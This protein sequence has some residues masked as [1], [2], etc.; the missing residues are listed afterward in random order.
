MASSEHQPSSDPSAIAAGL[1]GVELGTEAAKSKESVAAEN[2]TKFLR[3]PAQRVRVR[4]NN[5]QYDSDEK[6]G[7]SEQP[8]KRKCRPK[9]ADDKF[10]LKKRNVKDAIAKPVKAKSDRVKKDEDASKKRKYVRKKKVQS[11]VAVEQGEV[12]APCPPFAEEGKL[13]D[14]ECIGAVI[15]GDTLLA[16]VTGEDFRGTCRRAL[17]FR[18]EDLFSENSVLCSREN[19][20][21]AVALEPP[22]VQEVK[23]NYTQ[24]SRAMEPPFIEE[25]IMNNSEAADKQMDNEASESFWLEHGR[26][27][28]DI[29]T[30]RVY[31]RKKKVQGTVNSQ[32]SVVVSTEQPS[33]ELVKSD[34]TGTTG[35]ADTSVILLPAVD[36]DN[37]GSRRP[38]WDCQVENLKMSRSASSSKLKKKDSFEIVFN[39]LVANGK[40]LRACQCIQLI[41]KG[42]LNVH[43]DMK[44]QRAIRRMRVDM[45]RLH[46]SFQSLIAMSSKEPTLLQELSKPIQKKRSRTVTRRRKFGPLLAVPEFKMLPTRAIEQQRSIKLLKTENTEK[47]PTHDS[48][49]TSSKGTLLS[50]KEKVCFR[51][52]ELDLNEEPQPRFAELDP[53]AADG[54]HLYTTDVMG[55]DAYASQSYVANH[56]KS[57][58][59][60]EDGYFTNHQH[61]YNSPLSLATI[62]GPFVWTG[63]QIPVQNIGYTMG[64]CYSSQNCS[65]LQTNFA[66]GEGTEPLWD[67]TCNNI[68]FPSFANELVSIPVVRGG[69]TTTSDT[70]YH[71]NLYQ[72][73]VPH[74]GH[75]IEQGFVAE[76]DN[77]MFNNY[78]LVPSG[79]SSKLTLGQE[80]VTRV[81]NSLDVID[82]LGNY[83]LATSSIR[84]KVKAHVNFDSKTMPMWRALMGKE[85]FGDHQCNEDEE[86]KKWWKEERLIFEEKVLAFISCMHKIQGNRRFSPWNGSVTDSTMGVF[87]TQNVS[88]HLSSSA[89]MSLAAKFPVKSTNSDEAAQEEHE[90]VIITS[91]ESSGSNET[92]VVSPSELLDQGCLSERLSD[93][94]QAAQLQNSIRAVSGDQFA[95]QK[96][97]EDHLAISVSAFDG[98][99]DWLSQQGQTIQHQDSSDPKSETESCLSQPEQLTHPQD[100]SYSK[101]ETEPQDSSLPKSETEDCLSRLQQTTLPQA[102]SP[103][104]SETEECLSQVEQKT[105]F[106]DA[107]HPKCE[108]EERLSRQEELTTQP[109]DS[110]LATSETDEL[111]SQQEQ[112]TQ[113]QDSSQPIS[114]TE[115]T[116]PGPKVQKNKTPKIN[117]LE[118]KR[119]YCNEK[120]E[121]NGNHMDSVDWEAVRTAPVEVVAEAIKKRGQQNILAASMQKALNRVYEEL[122]SLD[123]EWLRDTPP[124]IAKD[125][126][127]SIDG[128]GLKSVECIRLLALEQVAFPVDTNVGRIA[129]RLGWV[130]LKDVPEGLQF[131]LL[132][133]YPMMDAI[134]KYLWPRLSELDQ[135]TLYELH[136]QMITFGKV[137][138]KKR[139]PYCNACPLRTNCKYF[140]SAY[141]SSSLPITMPMPSERDENQP[142]SD[143][144]SRLVQSLPTIDGSSFIRSE[145]S[146]E[147][148]VEMVTSPEEPLVDMIASEERLLEAPDSDSPESLIKMIESVNPIVEM[149]DSPEPENENMVV[150]DIEDLYLNAPA[151]PT[152][153]L[154]DEE[155]VASLSRY[156]DNKKLQLDAESSNAL[157]VSAR[158]ATI[159]ARKL[160]NIQDLRT[161]HLVYEI[162]DRHDL[163]RL[164]GLENRDPADPCLYLLSIWSP[165]EVASFSAHNTNA[166]SNGEYEK[167]ADEDY[168]LGTF[169]IPCRT[170]MG[171]RFPLN[172]T[173]FQVNE[174]FADHESSHHPIKISRSYLWYLK[175][176]VVY[177]GSST[178]SIT[179]GLTTQE[180]QVC[181]WRDYICVRGFDRKTREPKELHERLHKLK[182]ATQTKRS[183]VSNKNKEGKK[184]KVSKIQ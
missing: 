82:D 42:R 4:T 37:G 117:W 152:I 31:V 145:T 26:S 89:Y 64:N 173:Y 123:L 68:Q 81:D 169:L 58:I 12:V 13:I 69:F 182:T 116:I 38:A 159:P 154:N 32:L 126:L 41:R 108:T 172:G 14:T 23:F 138:C 183:G 149:P 87:L 134:Q 140:A 61:M 18:D 148:I 112:K 84:K 90:C 153:V 7:P 40:M 99:E 100:S 91:Q 120:R 25:V 80:L 35:M 20:L 104:E 127:L 16:S 47:W 88:D 49:V 33:A 111:L 52:Q 177:C 57:D 161:E 157:V 164:H 83:T 113:L 137:F 142:A 155:F 105:L 151:I 22:P 167:L 29:S 124:Q 5:T 146:H 53:L 76:V 109:Q 55:S 132:E 67:A 78:S 77:N 171:G 65:S 34:E 85:E 178:S 2:T 62:M 180:I 131:H 27:Q 181:F 56:G 150:D 39:P 133:E 139:S 118:T 115:R 74:A 174:V 92:V 163:L 119:K 107:F 97:A 170:A 72:Q 94:D 158:S 79:E 168:I 184:T 102:S 129:V 43:G 98:F 101:S 48:L 110:L 66:F 141:V 11:A 50:Q 176:C 36:G 71:Y 1:R 73:L 103:P 130:D 9:V 96:K 46:W 135:L 15:A 121:R 17:E 75:H 54:E 8:K 125:F 128:L 106:Q 162:P 28:K 30:P 136:Y 166:N 122:G 21:E 114:E 143:V 51:S 60:T 63:E 156:I 6:K 70:N 86:S 95:G 179:T 45:T 147:L 165:D 3:T 93:K 175:R 160:K 10:S 19:D 144:E 24:P 59:E 44:K